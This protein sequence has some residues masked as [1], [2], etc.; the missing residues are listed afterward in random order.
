MTDKPLYHLGDGIVLGIGSR[1]TELCDL[2][3]DQEIQID[4]RFIE[5]LEKISL[6]WTGEGYESF[7]PRLLAEGVLAEGP[8]T[9]DALLHERLGALDQLFL[10]SYSSALSER[11]KR[12]YRLTLDAHARR[13]RFFT[14]V[15]QCPTLPETSLRRALRVGD[16]LEVGKKR[17]LCVGDD[18][19][20]SIALAALGHDVTVFDIDDFLL[21][22]LRSTS[23]T[24]GLNVT[25]VEKDLRDPLDA[26]ERQ[27]YDLFL[28]DPM[29]NRDCFEI[30]LSRALALVPPGSP[31]YVAVYGPTERLFRAVA[32]EMHF[33]I[34][35]WHRRHNRYYSQY[36]KIHPYESDWVE[37]RRT[38]ET[39]IK[40]SPDEFCVPLNLYAE[41][42]YQRPPIFVAHYD[43]IEEPKYARPLFLDMIFDVVE[44]N[45]AFKFVERAH[46]L[47]QEWT[48]IHG[49]S[50]AG[51]LT[52]HVDR[53]R[54][55]LSLALF[56]MK[57]DVEDVLR[58]A[59]MSAYKTHAK[60]AKMGTT[61]DVWDLRVR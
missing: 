51:H 58:H 29:S 53:E 54:R 31:G 39:V 43:E 56:P 12:A 48:V 7:I 44:Q 33:P 24:L 32:Q 3:H 41:Q 57:A 27:S 4:F 26:S 36:M 46:L 13:K 60:A 1:M 28:T 22:F 50:E 42:F 37:I 61:R 11:A 5:P 38:S 6:G 18:D 20:V 9:V 55:T 47:G 52:L 21:N 45:T 14:R 10:S 35:A 15:G 49:A 59:V 19:L 2:K 8:A 40:H 34:E 23:T 17:V 25:V 30:F 16:A